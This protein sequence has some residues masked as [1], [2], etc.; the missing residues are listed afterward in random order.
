VWI[1]PTSAGWRFLWLRY[2]SY[3]VTD[4]AGAARELLADLGC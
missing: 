2:R 4:P 3:P 1:V